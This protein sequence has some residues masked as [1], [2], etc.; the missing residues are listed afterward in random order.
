MTVRQLIEQLQDMPQDAPVLFTC[1][2][3]DYHRTTQALPIDSV[4]ETNQSTLDTT[5]YS[6][7]G[8]CYN[9]D[10]GEEDTAWY[11]ETCD[12]MYIMPVCP[13]CGTNCVNE[14]GEEYGEENDEQD[15]PVVILN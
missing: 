4:V 1:N 7:S 2:Y 8:L 9:E 6:Q 11:C 5:P 14:A 3:G 10:E 15:I 12:E 13:K